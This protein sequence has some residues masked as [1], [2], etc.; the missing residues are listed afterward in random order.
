MNFETMLEEMREL[1]DHAQRLHI[2]QEH[3][4][5]GRVLAKVMEMAEEAARYQGH[6][7]E[8]LEAYLQG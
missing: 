1:L 7:A 8:A 6:K 2:E 4:T 5:A 3:E